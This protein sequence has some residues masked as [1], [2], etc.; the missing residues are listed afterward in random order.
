MPVLAAGCCVL[1]S[2]KAPNEA[3]V[4]AKARTAIERFMAGSFFN[5]LPMMYSLVIHNKWAKP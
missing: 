3:R 2:A 5:V 1:A 4:A